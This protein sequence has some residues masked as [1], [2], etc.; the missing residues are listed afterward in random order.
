MVFG[1]KYPKIKIDDSRC[2]TPFDCKKCLQICPQSVFEVRA[3]K[4]IRGEETDKKEPGAY[5]L[6]AYWRDKC[7][8]CGECVD[9]CPVSAL[10]M[11]LP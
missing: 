4:A 8:G 1:I 5:R 7:T 9:V 3:M 2:V 6:T 11:I 10:E